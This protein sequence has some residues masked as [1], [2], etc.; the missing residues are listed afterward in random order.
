MN[1]EEKGRLFL[2]ISKK[3]AKTAVERNKMKRWIREI[4][5]DCGLKGKFD[6][7]ISL[8]SRPEKKYAFFKENLLDLFKRLK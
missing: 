8:K 3:Y 1:I 6:I 4:Y 5:G 2:R 7:V